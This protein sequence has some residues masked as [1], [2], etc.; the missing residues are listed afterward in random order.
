MNVMSM[1]DPVADM[2]TR[3]RNAYLVHKKE[4]RIPYSKL[5]EAIAGVMLKQ[6][7]L[8]AVLPVTL[9]NGATV[10]QIV[11]KYFE[12]ESVVSRLGMV[13]RASRRVYC[14]KDEIPEIMGGGGIVIISTSRGVVSGQQARANGLGGEILCFVE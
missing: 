6:G 3:I 1:S 12:D 5:K 9:P 2:L 7:Y 10:L 14:K 8:R 11:L 13:S 4:V